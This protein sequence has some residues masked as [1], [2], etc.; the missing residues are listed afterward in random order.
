YAVGLTNALGASLLAPQQAAA[1]TA[2]HYREFDPA[3]SSP[4]PGAD[5]NQMSPALPRGAVPQGQGAQGI[6]IPTTQQEAECVNNQATN[7]ILDRLKQVQ[8]GHTIKQI[9]NSRVVAVTPDDIRVDFEVR[10]VY[11]GHRH[12]SPVYHTGKVSLHFSPMWVGGTRVYR[13]HTHSHD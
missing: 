12:F 11:P 9:T 10:Y 7:L 13:I 2:G 5:M 4:A 6:V 3:A 8:N 1:P